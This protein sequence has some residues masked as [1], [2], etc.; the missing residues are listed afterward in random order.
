MNT[1]HKPSPWLQAVA[2][3]GGV[4]GE[5]LKQAFGEWSLG[6][7]A[8]QTGPEG[9]RVAV[10]MTT[11]VHGGISFEGKKRTYKPVR[12]AVAPPPVDERWEK[13]WQPLTQFVCVGVDQAHKDQ[14]MTY[15]SGAWTARTAFMTLIRRFVQRGEREFPV[16]ALS[17][18]PSTSSDGRDYFEPVF[19]IVD[20]APIEAF[21]NVAPPEIAAE[22]IQA[23]PA[24]EPEPEN[25]EADE[26]PFAPIDDLQF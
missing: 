7:V 9:L 14:L 26:R 1:I 22:E 19:E 21:S 15:S 12:Y 6:G 4:E 10:I 3:A 11:A 25:E 2:N 16:C 13:P 18:K 24:P 23:L 5:L 8:V 17:S 20:W